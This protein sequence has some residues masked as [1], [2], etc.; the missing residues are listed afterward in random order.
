MI[1]VLDELGIKHELMVLKQ[2]LVSMKYGCP[3]T[4]FL[5]PYTI[6]FFLMISFSDTDPM[7][8]R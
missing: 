6:R 1:A 8:V 7:L 3:E 4:D 5:A 2:E